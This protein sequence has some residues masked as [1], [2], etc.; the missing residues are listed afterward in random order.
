M[1][2]GANFYGFFLVAALWV[3]VYFVWASWMNRREAE[4]E[5]KAI[6]ETT[7]NS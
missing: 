6:S 3:C 5:K 2:L 1:G 7:R 4:R